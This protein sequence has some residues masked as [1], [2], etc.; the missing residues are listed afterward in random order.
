MAKPKVT[1]ILPALNEEK[2]IGK[3]IDEIP[4]S[5]LEKAGYIIQVLVADGNSTDQTRKIAER[6]GADIVIEPRKGKGVAIKTGP[7]QTIKDVVN[8]LDKLNELTKDCGH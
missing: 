7:Y 4:I 1:I 6:K 5:D 8:N 3:V 2:T